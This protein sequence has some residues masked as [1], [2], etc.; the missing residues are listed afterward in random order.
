MLVY[1]ELIGAML[2]Q[3]SGTPS[4]LAQRA[5][6]WADITNPSSAVPMFYDGSSSFPISLDQSTAMITQNSGKGCTVDWSQG[7]NQ[8]VTLTDNC[9]IK[10]ANPQS[11]K[12][13][14]L[15]VVQNNSGATGLQSGPAYV[16]TLDMPDQEVG[17]GLWQP[18]QV[19]PMG[20][21]K[22]YEWFYKF[23]ITAPYTTVPDTAVFQ[24]RTAVLGTVPAG[25][26][27]SPDG[28][29]VGVTGNA[30]PFSSWYWLSDGS[31]GANS[32]FGDR[33]VVTPATAVGTLLATAYSPNGKIVY[34]G[35]STTPFINGYFVDRYT[36]VGTALANPA[37]LPAGV[38]GALAV[39]PTGNYIVAG[40][41]TTPFMS[42]YPTVVGNTDGFG[43]KLANP[44]TLPPSTVQSVAWCP[45]GDYLAIASAA[46]PFLM[47]YPFNDTGVVGAATFGAPVTNPSTIPFIAPNTSGYH[48]L[49]WRPQGDFIALTMSTSGLYIVPFNR[50]TGTFGT[51]F[52]MGSLTTYSVAWT[53]CGTYLILTTAAGGYFVYDFST[54]TPVVVAFDTA[55][56]LSSCPDA[57]VHPNGNYMLVVNNSGTPNIYQAPLPRRQ[58]NYLRI[59]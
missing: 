38:V 51:A 22:V 54:L 30:T 35:G 29:A 10:F 20:D 4:G 39:H 3:V 5:R 36:P 24:P 47:V 28:K 43:V 48:A 41:A 42:C 56:G 12:T 55:N 57:L 59:L 33:N 52:T 46:S 53:P 9:V 58:K 16:H 40:H 50:T 21:C 19:I 18:Q 6:I 32:L 2:E 7:L 23:G 31:P 25:I 8:Q 37:T 17:R 49:A 34:V 27:I 11:G 1:G 14:T 44:S 15:A 26:A 13:H 45:Q